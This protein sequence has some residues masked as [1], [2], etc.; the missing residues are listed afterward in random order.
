MTSKILHELFNYDSLTGIF[1]QTGKGRTH[2][3]GTVS[4]TRRPDNYIQITY[5]KKFYLAHRLAFLYMTG[6]FPKEEIDHKNHIKN[7]NRW[8]NLKEISRHNNS[9][10]RTL[11]SNNKTGYHG[12]TTYGKKFR[13]QI[14]NNK[15][16]GE[17]IGYYNTLDEAILVRKKKELEYG[18][19]K[20]HR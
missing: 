9:K 3:K 4:G 11:S 16:R 7:D 20:N 18:Y 5:R 1:T 19:N 6:N 17:T 13:V 12:I 15:K 10:N 14:H 8:S 2:K